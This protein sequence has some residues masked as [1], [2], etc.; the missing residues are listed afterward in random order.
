M[1][2]PTTFRYENGLSRV[3]NLQTGNYTLTPDDNGALV[4]INSGTGK[5]I[6]VPQYLPVG[7]TCTVIQGGAGQI[8]FAESS[9]NINNVSSHTK[10]SGQYAEVS[11][12]SS[13]VD[14]FILAGSTGA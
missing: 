12:T 7:F 10:T 14:E 5:T 11:L 1:A 3:V 2:T 4:I 9:T 13:G 8:T 6:T